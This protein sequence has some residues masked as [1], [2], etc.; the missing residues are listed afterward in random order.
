[1][2]KAVDTL[3]QEGDTVVREDLESLESVRELDALLRKTDKQA[4]AKPR[5]QKTKKETELAHALLGTVQVRGRVHSEVKEFIKIFPGIAPDAET[6]AERLVEVLLGGEAAIE[7]HDASA[8]DEVYGDFA[9]TFVGH[10]WSERILG[11]VG[12]RAILRAAALA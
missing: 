2:L 12:R 5:R 3:R 4:T 9:D 1:M 6:F 11:L 7:S 8:A 10:G